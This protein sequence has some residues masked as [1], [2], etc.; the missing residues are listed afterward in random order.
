M[1]EWQEP[2]IKFHARLDPKGRILIP[3]SDRET[4]GIRGND[5]VE[6]IVRKIT[7]DERSKIITILKSAYIIAK[8]GVRGYIVIPTNARVELGLSQGDIVEVLIL[9]VHKFESLVT[10]EGK[11]LIKRVQVFSQ[12]KIVRSPEEEYDLLNKL[13]YSYLFHV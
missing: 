2:L 8:V 9:A 3:K 1:R 10:H 6:A 12:A 4:L 11:E 13:G 7:I 5:Y